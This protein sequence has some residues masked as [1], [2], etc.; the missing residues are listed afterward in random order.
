MAEQALKIMQTTTSTQEA[1][2][3]SVSGMTVAYDRKPVLWDVSFSARAGAIAAVVG[4]NGAGKSTLLKAALGLVPALAGQTLI[5]G[6]PLSE[7]RSRVA[8]MPQRTAVDWDFPATA[9]DVVMMGLYAELG[10]LRWPG[11]R[12]RQK[13]LDCLE[14]VD[15]AAFAHRQIGQLSGGQQQRVFMARALAQAADVYLMDEPFA[16]VDAA[17]EAVILKTLKT[18]AS[19]GKCVIVVHHDLDTVRAIFDDVLLI[20]RQVVASGPIETAMSEEAVRKT[21]SGRIGIRRHG[22]PAG[23]VGI[24]H[25][26]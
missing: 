25:H 22:E 4:P 10:F 16:G 19:S 18:L 7:M 21:Y 20:N 14:A 3:L 9:L 12:H 13:A 6:R 24:A 11:A 2:A 1:P 26:V 23:G 5:F 8:Y 15:M 17:T